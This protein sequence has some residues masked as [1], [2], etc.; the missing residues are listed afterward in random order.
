MNDQP[1]QEGSQEAASTTLHGSCPP[2]TS[3][4]ERIAAMDEAFD[5]RGDVTI[6]TVDGQAIQGYVFDR[7]T[8]ADQPYVRLIPTGSTERVSIGYAQIA[9]LEFSGRDTAA[10]K[11]WE[12]WV[13]KYQEKKAR[14]EAANLHP[15]SLDE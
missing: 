2:L 15:D 8:E 5:Y 9:R 10:G 6:H 14:G 4:Q 13:K 7:R 11:S 1:N 3:Q 12:T